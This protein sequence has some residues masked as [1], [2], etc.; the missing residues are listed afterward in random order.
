MRF[1]T[2]DQK[3]K[4]VNVCGELR[5][6]ASDDA[7]FLSRVFTGDENWIYGYDP[8]IKQQA[9]E[10]KSPNSTRTKSRAC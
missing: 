2:V 7:T 1:L 8:D 9:S 5:Q 6:I 3:Q 10:W 4:R